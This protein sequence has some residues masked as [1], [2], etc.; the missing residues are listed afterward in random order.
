MC[1]N[2]I[3]VHL[4]KIKR[5][6]DKYLI[7]PYNLVDFSCNKHNEFCYIYCKK[8]RKNICVKCERDWNHLKHENE[9]ELYNIKEINE[10]IDKQKENLIKDKEKCWWLLYFF[11]K[12]FWLFNFK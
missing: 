3:K 12:V 7:Y 8:C 10:L 2:W 5:E 11:K 4:R 6:K 9:T 1:N